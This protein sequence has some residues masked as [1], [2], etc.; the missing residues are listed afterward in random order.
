MLFE[1]SVDLHGISLLSVVVVAH[2]WWHDEGFLSLSNYEQKVYEAWEDEQMHTDIIN[3]HYQS[4]LIYRQLVNFLS[5]LIWAGEGIIEIVLLLNL[6]GGK[7]VNILSSS[8][9]SSNLKF[10]LSSTLLLNI[11]PSSLLLLPSSFETECF[12]MLLNSAW[13]LSFMRMSWDDILRTLFGSSLASCIHKCFSAC[14]RLILWSAFLR[15]LLTKHLRLE[16]Y[17]SHCSLLYM[18][19]PV[20]MFLTVSEWYSD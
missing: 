5:F 3:Y 14:C 18:I 19:N 4:K 20:R 11:L 17:L 1:Q 6:T 9:E 2:R 7:S 8:E 15:R 12:R 13:K 16:L 10:Y